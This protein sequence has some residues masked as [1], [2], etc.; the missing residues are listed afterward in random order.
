MALRSRRDREYEQIV[1][2]VSCP[3]SLFALYECS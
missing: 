2:V 1:F 3:S